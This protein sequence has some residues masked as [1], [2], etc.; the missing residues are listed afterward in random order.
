MPNFHIGAHF[1][2][3]NNAVRHR[4]LVQRAYN[5]QAER[6]LASFTAGRPARFAKPGT[7]EEA[8][9]ISITVAQAERQE[10]WGE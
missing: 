3:E 4:P 10:M 9:G 6:M 5:E 8:L 1:S 2:P 7:A